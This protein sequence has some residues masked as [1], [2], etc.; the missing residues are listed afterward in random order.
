[1]RDR[2][3]RSSGS[4]RTTYCATPFGSR[5]PLDVP[6]G[7]RSTSGGRVSSRQKTDLDIDSP[8][9]FGFSRRR[10]A[11][12]PSRDCPRA[13][14]KGTQPQPEMARY[15]ALD[16]VHGLDSAHRSVTRTPG[17]LAWNLPRGSR[18]SSVSPPS[19]HGRFLRHVQSALLAQPPHRVGAF[20]LSGLLLRNA[21][22]A[23]AA[24][25]QGAGINQLD[26]SAGVGL[27]QNP[28]GHLVARVI[29]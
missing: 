3:V 21:V 19:E 4:R 15:G 13:V 14:R 22:D 23:A 17:A 2:F 16:R 28:L 12:N 10:R 11:N 20:G 7:S 25:E 5:A 18:H 8:H 6:L 29:E 27:F 26:C 9:G 24:C 1:M